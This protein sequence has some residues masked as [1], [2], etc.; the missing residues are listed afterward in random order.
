MRQ[1][2][3]AI[4]WHC[5]G[6]TSK[7]KWF[8]MQSKPKLTHFDILELSGKGLHLSFAIF[9]DCLESAKVGINQTLELYQHKLAV[10][11]YEK[12][13]W[14][15][16]LQLIR[17]S[18]EGSPV[19]L[20]AHLHYLE[21]TCLHPSCS[22]FVNYLFPKITLYISKKQWLKTKELPQVNIFNLYVKKWK[23]TDTIY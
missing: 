19:P 7:Y 15:S 4:N 9:Q 3:E 10:V 5:C 17:K 13:N 11:L 21:M 20:Q 18:P 16:V 1:R 22:H 12:C 14:M 6:F 2:R 8:P 23:K